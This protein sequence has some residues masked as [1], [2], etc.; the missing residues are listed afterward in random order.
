MSSKRSVTAKTKASK[1]RK[2]PSSNCI[3]GN[4]RYI[5]S[6]CWKSI[7]KLTCIFKLQM[8]SVSNRCF[9]VGNNWTIIMLVSPL[10]QTLMR[11]GNVRYYW[12]T[13]SHGSFC[14]FSKTNTIWCLQ[15]KRNLGCDLPLKD[16]YNG[17]VTLIEPWFF[18]LFYSIK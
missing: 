4:T 10:D 7:F 14:F 8:K 13:H 18:I 11:W 15:M 1:L 5:F 17:I 2:H 12:F 3:P 6:T 16:T 9:C